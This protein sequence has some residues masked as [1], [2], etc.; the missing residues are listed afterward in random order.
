MLDPREQRRSGR[1]FAPLERTRDPRLSDAI[2]AVARSEGSHAPEGWSKPLVVPDGAVEVIL[3]SKGRGVLHKG[4]RN[5]NGSLGAHPRCHAIPARE[6][7]PTIAAYDYDN[8]RDHARY[9]RYPW[10]F[11]GL[12]AEMGIIPVV[13]HYSRPLGTRLGTQ[14]LQELTPSTATELA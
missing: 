1:G 12:V 3:R 7:L 2:A 9:C 11:R 14:L 8:L 4:W 6:V 10:C 13:G 5:P